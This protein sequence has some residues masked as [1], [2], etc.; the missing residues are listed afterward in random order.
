MIR[1]NWFFFKFLVFS[2]VFFLAACQSAQ[3]NE[4]T[5]GWENVTLQAAGFGEINQAWSAADR[6]TAVQKAK[7]DA[8]AQLETRIL[9]I[10]INP[11]RKVEDLTIEDESLRKK[12]SSYVRGAKIIRTE[13]SETGVRVFAELFLG[14]NF[15]AT[16]GLN[17]K[18]SNTPSNLSRD[19]GLSR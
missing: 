19:E 13:N 9:A 17:Q 2:G 16:L 14:G 11:S 5:P 8:Y 4:G 6:M 10:Q 15:K 3:I 7:V 12:I 1:K 18:R